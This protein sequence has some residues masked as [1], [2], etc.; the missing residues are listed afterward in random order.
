MI[1]TQA[2]VELCD[3]QLVVACG[4]V[5][6]HPAGCLLVLT[7]GGRLLQRI[8]FAS[9]IPA[10]LSASEDGVYA[11]MWGMGGGAG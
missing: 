7:V 6:K 8:P 4:G 3:D 2:P 9:C 10:S 5:D 1:E 11:C